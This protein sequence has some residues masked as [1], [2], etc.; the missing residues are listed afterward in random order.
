MK[1]IYILA[2]AVFLLV[3]ILMCW[4]FIF[5][6][7]EFAT[8]LGK[9]SKDA[10]L[11]EESRFI[12]TWETE[13]IEEDNRFIGFNGIYVFSSDGTGSIG[14]LSSTWDVEEGKLII[15]YYERISSV[16]YEYSFS[17]DESILTLSNSNGFLEF[18]KNID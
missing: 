11:N 10:A 5:N 4:F 2:G 17:E 12:G 15:Y 1:K 9:K 3:L 8:N 18:T 13:Y 16:S 7:Y 14:G 6:Y